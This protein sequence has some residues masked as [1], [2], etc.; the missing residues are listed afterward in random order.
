[1]IFNCTKFKVDFNNYSD[2]FNIV[3]QNRL[4]NKIHCIEMIFVSNALDCWQFY[5]FC[6]LFLRTWIDCF[7]NKISENL[8]TKK[9]IFWW[10]TLTFINMFLSWIFFLISILFLNLNNFYII[11]MIFTFIAIFYIFVY[12]CKQTR[13]TFILNN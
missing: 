2:Y 8:L 9:L 12:C 1:M 10:I 4:F 3:N 7:K 13:A 5:F 11:L 6:S